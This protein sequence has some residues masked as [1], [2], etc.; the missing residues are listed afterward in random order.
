MWS[1]NKIL[2]CGCSQQNIKTMFFLSALKS[3]C[4]KNIQ[5]NYVLMQN[6]NT[7][8]NYKK[9]NSNHIAVQKNSMQDRD[10]HAQTNQIINNE[11]CLQLK[12]IRTLSWKTMFVRMS[13][14]KHVFSQ[15]STFPKTSMFTALIWIDRRTT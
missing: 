7:G 5:A 13:Y 10:H 11:E 6:T 8:K 1:G 2:A 4:L 15:F 14:K 12:S 9:A 3:T